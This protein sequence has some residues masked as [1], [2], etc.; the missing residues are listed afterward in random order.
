MSDRVY[1][2]VRNPK[3]RILPHWLRVHLGE[4]YMGVNVYPV[5]TDDLAEAR[6][7]VYLGAAEAYIYKGTGQR[8]NGLENAVVRAYRRAAIAKTANK[9]STTKN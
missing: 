5:W 6:A 9:L 7:F 4:R 3:P 8:Y 1:V 2:V